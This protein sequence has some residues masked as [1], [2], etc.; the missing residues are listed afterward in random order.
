MTIF[1]HKSRLNGLH[2]LWRLIDDEFWT[3]RF[4]FFHLENSFYV[5]ITGYSFYKLTF[6]LTEQQPAQSY[7]NQVYSQ[8]V[9]PGSYYSTCTPVIQSGND[10]DDTV[11]SFLRQFLEQESRSLS[12]IIKRDF[13]IF[14]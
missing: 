9:Y 1:P 14:F 8:S 2:V 3:E 12:N 6:N 5:L 11:G 4:V 10:L 7:Q 13:K